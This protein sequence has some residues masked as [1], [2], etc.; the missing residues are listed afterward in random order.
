MS[1]RLF[2]VFYVEIILE[3]IAL[4]Q[5]DQFYSVLRGGLI[6]AISAG[7]LIFALTMIL[8]ADC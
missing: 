6:S 2:P 4:S 3:L 5:F 1:D 8:L 7:F